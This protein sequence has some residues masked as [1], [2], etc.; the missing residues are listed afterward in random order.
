MTSGA[1]LG[2]L[3]REALS[4]LRGQGRRS[5]LALLGV[6]IGSA[7][8]V[9]LLTIAQMAEG[10][11]MKRFLKTGVDVLQ[12][13]GAGAEARLNPA[14]LERLVAEDP[15]LVLA[16]LVATTSLDVRIGKRVETAM[17]AAVTPAMSE[18]AGLTPAAGRLMVGLDDCARSAVVG[19]ALAE[20]LSAPGAPVHPGVMA[21]LGGYGFRVVGVLSPAPQQA[22][23]PIDYDRAIIIPLACGRRVMPS[24]TAS[25]ALIRVGPA[26]DT[27]MAGERLTARLSTPSAPIEVKDARAMIAAM[28]QQLA[29]F[30]GV[31]TAIGS[32]SLL[33]GGVGVMNVMLMTVMERRREIGLRAAIGASPGE[34]RLLFL[35]EAVMLGLAGGVTGD[36]LGL[37]AAALATVF[38]PMDF[39]ISAPVLILGAVVSSGVALIFGL[40]PAIAA[41]RI[42]PIEALRA[43]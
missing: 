16:A 35:F 13:R 38:M 8:I 1:A 22:L 28:Q 10:E 40:Y 26:V 6:T 36:A 15:E 14:M 17:V 30:T 21:Y 42:P 39:A 37:G 29:L 25:V 2:D 32:I 7:A 23:N 41:S 3:W 18:L 33:V 4:N 43:D 20:T 19:A 31:M 27:A 24:D 9:A 5:I 34:I 12:V 11:A